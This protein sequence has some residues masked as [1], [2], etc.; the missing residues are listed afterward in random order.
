MLL[1]DVVMRIDVRGELPVE[2]CM[3]VA[4]VV[5]VVALLLIQIHW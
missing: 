5:V 4:V 3:F 1:L 2:D